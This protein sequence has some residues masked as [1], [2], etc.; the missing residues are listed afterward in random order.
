VP[1]VKAVEGAAW[2]QLEQ[3]ND[4]GYSMRLLAAHGF[5]FEDL[6]LKREE[7]ERAPAALRAQLLSVGDSIGRTQPLTQA[8]V[9]ETLVKMAAD[10]V[11]YVPPRATVWA[12]YGRDPEIGATWGFQMKRVFVAPVR[13]HA[14]VLLVGANQ[15][16]SSERGGAAVG[17]VAGAEYLPS[18]WSSTR[19]QPSILVRGGWMFAANDD[20]GFSTCPDPGNS[21]I[22]YC[23]RPM[24]QAG[25]SATLLE[26]FRLQ[27]TG[28]WYPPAQNGEAHQWAIGPAIGYQWGF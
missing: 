20:A 18:W 16:F 13:L 24:I 10:E 22:G 14:A 23:S 15:I 3:E 4:A 11:A 6:G 5:Q 26:R 19:L 17:L 25:V 12:M 1:F 21:T 9:I 7:A 2:R 27:L 28:N 8:F